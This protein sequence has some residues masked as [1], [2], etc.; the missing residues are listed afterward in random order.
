VK[1]P[2]ALEQ[3]KQPATRSAD[4]AAERASRAADDA[5]KTKDIA[6]PA[7]LDK[8]LAD[9]LALTDEMV[10]QAGINPASIY[11]EADELLADAETYAAAY[12]AAALCQLRN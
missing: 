5:L 3:I 9:E 11:R 10:R 2:A 1:R 12:R 6:D 7:T 8:L 4:P